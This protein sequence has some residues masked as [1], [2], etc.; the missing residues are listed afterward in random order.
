M[1]LSC[2]RDAHFEKVGFGRAR[3]VREGLWSDFWSPLGPLLA[4]PGGPEAR[5]EG[6]K[7]RGIFEAP[8][9]RILGPSRRILGPPFGA[10]RGSGGGSEKRAFFGY[11]KPVRGR[12][13][14]R[15]L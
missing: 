7:K 14:R 3:R 4:S 5:K 11:G 10:E 6:D 1:R 13:R 9:L 15:D 2:T 12:R 8:F